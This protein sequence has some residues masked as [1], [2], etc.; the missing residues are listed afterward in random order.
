MGPLQTGL[1]MPLMA[2]VWAHDLTWSEVPVAHCALPPTFLPVAV[3]A[4]PFIHLT[5]PRLNEAAEQ[6]PW[7]CVTSDWPSGKR[8]GRSPIATY[9]VEPTW[10][11][12]LPSGHST[13]VPKKA[14]PGV[15]WETHPDALA[16]TE[17]HV[18]VVVKCLP[19]Q[20]CTHPLTL[21]KGPF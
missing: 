17:S 14:L 6:R 13:S 9:V 12:M 4:L 15:P 7:S 19:V 21:S 10:A 3:E 5:R 8:L 18:T 16:A 1:R 11:A 20:K 2:P